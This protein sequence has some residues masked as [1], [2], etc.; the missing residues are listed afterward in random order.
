M[1]PKIAKN[2]LGYVLV[3]LHVYAPT[4][5][6]RSLFIFFAEFF[7]TLQGTA[8]PSTKNINLFGFDINMNFLFKVFDFLS[9]IPSI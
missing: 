9:V 6:L 4:I 1:A 7:R 3:H 5:C 2:P 8:F